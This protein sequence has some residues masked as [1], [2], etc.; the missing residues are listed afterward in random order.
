MSI[1]DKKIKDYEETVQKGISKSFLNNDQD[2]ILYLFKDMSS[3][4]SF[5]LEKINI[6]KFLNY[7]WKFLESE[8]DKINPIK[9]EIKDNHL[10]FETRKYIAHIWVNTIEESSA[11]F[12]ENLIHI[13]ETTCTYKTNLFQGKI[14]EFKDSKPNLTFILE[15]AENTDNFFSS[16]R[17]AC[18]PHG[19]LKYSENASENFLTKRSALPDPNNF[20]FDFDKFLVSSENEKWRYTILYFRQNKFSSL[21][22]IYELKKIEEI[23]KK[24][25]DKYYHFMKY[26]E[27]EMLSGFKTKEK[28]KS[29]WEKFYGS[30]ISSFS[31]GA[32][33]IVY[34]I[35]N[36]KGIGQ[37]NS[38]PVGADLFFE[39]EDAYIHI[40]LKTVQ[41]DNIGDFNTTVSV[42][43][44][45]NSYAGNIIIET[46]NLREYKPSLP[47]YYC[48]NTENQKV[49]L[50]Y[51]ATIL[52]DKSN[53][54]IY[55]ISLLCMP[56]GF[57][58]KV[59]GSM[60][61]QAGKN[62]DET[63]YSFSK[64][65]NFISFDSEK[66]VKCILRNDEKI[67]E[68]N[69]KNLAS[70]LTYYLSLKI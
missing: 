69:T 39:V 35:F 15:F 47:Y 32:E 13:K 24:Y 12:K 19:N 23:E 65:D 26:C 31:V 51:F 2:I 38:S 42:E 49:C 10:M 20:Y 58:E 6:T 29:D 9:C 56:N 45:Q 44:N 68:C 3:K 14:D 8:H 43:K 48:E 40:D 55:I 33:R 70:S 16:I 54:D 34:S 57:L 63:R 5:P 4:E 36:G 53:L 41:L 46:K 25:L 11:F 21:D 37:P 60:N 64:T 28:I 30:S 1:T 22:E 17:L 59:Y 66:R 18:I 62:T 50:T 27:D 52:Y 61:L 7:F 67:R